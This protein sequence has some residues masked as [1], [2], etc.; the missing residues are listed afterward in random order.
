MLSLVDNTF[1]DLFKYLNDYNMNKDEEIINNNW[2][3][4]LY[5]RGKAQSQKVY[6]YDNSKEYLKNK[7]VFICGGCELSYVHLYLKYICNSYHTFE[8]KT[9][10][11]IFDE[12]NNE[13]TIIK[14]FDADY[15]ILSNIQDLKVILVKYTTNGKDYFKENHYT[16]LVKSINDY[17]EKY[18]IGIDKLRSFSNKP[19]FIMG[20][21]YLSEQQYF[22]KNDYLNNDWSE[23]ELHTY[24]Q[25][26]LIE[27]CREKNIYF[28]NTDS[29]FERYNKFDAIECYE[30]PRYGHLTYYGSAI[31]AEEF[32]NQVCIV[33][34][35]LPRIKCVVMDCDN[36]LWNGILIED[37]ENGIFIN[38]KII[39][40]L[41][42]L[43]FRGIIISLCSKNPPEFK[44][45]IYQILSNPWWGEDLSRYLLYSKINWEPKSKN[46]NQIAKELNISLDTI[47]FFDDSEF[48]RREVEE[49]AHEVRVFKD[50]DI[51]F[52]LNNPIFDN[53]FG[54]LTNTA[55]T[56]I[57]T[58]INNE[59]RNNDLEKI[60]EENSDKSDENNYELFMIK[61]EFKLNIYEASDNDINRINELIQR[62]NQLNATLKRTEYSDITN[63]S[64]N[65][66][67]Y[68]Y[69]VDL[70]DKYSNYGTVGTIILKKIN[71]ETI[72]IIEFALSCRAMGK[73][74]ED[75]IILFLFETFNLYKNIIINI[76]S[77][78]K[79]NSLI[80]TF[81]KYNFKIENKI[82]IHKLSNKQYDKIV[83]FDK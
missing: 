24:I 8:S 27:L 37:D 10:M 82:Y 17:F 21:L 14:E 63:Y 36:T 79:N 48:E 30:S 71:E 15:Y 16:N 44:D 53:Q 61:S 45:K 57:D 31:F 39:N 56:R 52:C 28:L 51:Y 65:A 20:W 2:L 73:K 54:K 83:W 32:Y 67:Y 66:N 59:K 58:Y 9:S 26:K 78:I 50:T 47:A 35:H 3:P 29:I 19:I 70:D 80:K 23:Y 74:V 33:D 6:T 11:H 1:P 7:K 4:Q 75:A 13:N 68:L 46:I 5:Y 64:N 18:S 40:I 41:I 42:S 69:C 12:L 34:K 22:G 43:V 77:N 25:I 62:T 72:E 55:K 49:N 81:E 76:Q 60:N 38:K